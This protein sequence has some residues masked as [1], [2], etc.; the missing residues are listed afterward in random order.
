MPVLPD[1]VVDASCEMC[2]NTNFLCFLPFPTRRNTGA[3]LRVSTFQSTFGHS[4]IN[5]MPACPV[6]EEV[7]D[8]DEAA[9]THHV[10]SHFDEQDGQA[11]GSAESLVPTHE[12]SVDVEPLTT[13]I[14][15]ALFAAKI[16]PIWVRRRGMAMSTNVWVRSTVSSTDRRWQWSDDID[17]RRVRREQ[18]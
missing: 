10:N 18:P 4:V 7:V 12:R 1:I 3:P 11:A 17:E 9:F 13:V 15:L 5:H 6:C 8:A 14:Q 16:S 2:V